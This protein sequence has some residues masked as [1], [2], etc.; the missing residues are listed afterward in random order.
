MEDHNGHLLLEDRDDGG[1]RVSLV[2][3]PKDRLVETRKEE[4]EDPMKVATNLLA[5]GS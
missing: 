5:H 3:D 4:A 1:A 2:F